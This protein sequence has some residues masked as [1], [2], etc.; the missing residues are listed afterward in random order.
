V[1]HGSN[2]LSAGA[3]KKNFMLRLQFGFSGVYWQTLS[4]FGIP[5]F[6]ARLLL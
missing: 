1:S 5:L 2:L 4:V 6:L 3:F